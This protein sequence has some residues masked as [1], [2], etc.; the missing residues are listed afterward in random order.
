M[1]TKFKLFA[2]ALA[3]TALVPAAAAHAQASADYGLHA[4]ELVVPINKSQVVSTPER[5]DRAMIGNSDIADVLPIS[6]RSIY[7]LGKS[8]G[9][10]SLT[11]YD[12]ANRVIAVMDVTVGPDID[13]M[14]RQLQALMPSDDVDI[15]LSN[16]SIVLSGTVPDAGMADRIAR[17]ATAY[18][19]DNVINLLG[20]GASQQVMLEVRFAEVSRQVGEQL[21]VSGFAFNEDGDFGAAIGNGAGVSPSTS[22]LR[23][24][25]ITDAFGVFG[26]LFELGDLSVEAYL[27]T[28]ERNGL[29]R[30][31]A[32]PTLVA[33]SGESANFLAGGEFPVPVSQ[34]N[35]GGVAGGGNAITV[36]FKPFGVSLAFTPTVLGNDVINLVVEPEVSSIDPSASVTVNGL[37]VPGLQTR[38]ART[39]LEVRDGESFAIAGLLRDETQT[40][41]NQLPLLGSLPIIG[42]LFRS[43]SYQ[44]GETELLIV[45]TPRLVQPIRPDQVRL[46][47]DR[48]PSPEVADVLLNGDVYQPQDLPPA[49]PASTGADYEY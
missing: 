37:T 40:T 7:V 5:I 42:S 45:V 47:T 27:D 16:G 48:V 19:G 8:R 33:L 15:S 35:G 11:L 26:A 38:R 46:P 13:G 20:M 2:A 6:D 29:S 22:A 36:L 9:T 4:G 17:L 39:T 24:D 34:G 49:A 43:T 30:T 18:A 44:R 21:G 3:A 25:T 31:L 28:L 23:L 1:I 10:T 32:E 14:R 12:N 41:V